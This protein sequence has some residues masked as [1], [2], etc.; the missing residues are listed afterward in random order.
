MSTSGPYCSRAAGRWGPVPPV[1]GA[2]YGG[3]LDS[4]FVEDVTIMDG[5]EM[6]P[7]TPFTKIWRLRNSG[8]IPWAPQTKLVHVG[9]DELGNVFVVPLELPEHGLLPDQEVEA[10]VDLVAPEKAG[11]YVSHWRLASPAGPKFGHRV[12]V[13]IQ[14]V[15]K[16]NVSFKPGAS[17]ILENDA[18]KSQEKV[19][20]ETTLSAPSATYESRESFV[21]A[22]HELVEQPA[23]RNTYQGVYLAN[24]LADITEPFSGLEMLDTVKDVESKVDE[25]PVDAV[26]KVAELRVDDSA[27]DDEVKLAEL[28]EE[29]S[30]VAVGGEEVVPAEN[31]VLE[32]VAVVE[33]SELGGGFSMVEMPSSK[34]T[35]DA[36]YNSKDGSQV[37]SVSSTPRE[38]VDVSRGI[39]QQLEEDVGEGE[40]VEDSNNPEL[41]SVKLAAMGFSDRKLN[42]ELL[43]KNKLDLRRTLDD[44][45]AAA[46]WDPILEELE[47]MGFYDT[48][49]N[50]RLMFKN[51]GSVKRVVKELVQMYKEPADQGNAKTTGL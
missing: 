22:S 47:E 20:V 26:V 39:K 27:V 19:A 25:V 30:P 48:E 41:L 29:N 11:R 34:P 9:G 3:K 28:R 12:W 6:A 2:V 33:S 17:E 7:G 43:V 5:T 45:F 24:R 1:N 37:N 13:V 40:N 38:E 50:R 23:V 10:A 35:Y 21:K 36:V 51:N 31:V 46:E 32:E 18:D 16:D 15:T 8:K 44:L 4:R 14:V 42:I 49:M